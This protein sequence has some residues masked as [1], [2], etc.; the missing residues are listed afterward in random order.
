MGESVAKC[1]VRP[2]ARDSVHRT[3]CRGVHICTSMALL[4]VLYL[5]LGT[6][7]GRCLNKIE[8]RAVGR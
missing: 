1:Y 6:T 4:V 8:S 5:G 3:H 7:L 2:R